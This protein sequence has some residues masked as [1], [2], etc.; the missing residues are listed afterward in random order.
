MEVPVLL[1]A[2]W[3]GDASASST[4]NKALKDI[5]VHCMGT[6]HLN[7]SPK[8]LSADLSLRLTVQQHVHVTYDQ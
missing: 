3:L 7:P 6:E 4:V 5:N 2:D 1:P 8:G